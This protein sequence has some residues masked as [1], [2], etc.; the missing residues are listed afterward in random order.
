MLERR[1]TSNLRFSCVSSVALGPAGSVPCEADS[2]TGVSA[3]IVERFR[4]CHGW[5][6][7]G[8]IVLFSMVHACGDCRQVLSLSFCLFLANGPISSI[9]FII[10]DGTTHGGQKKKCHP[11][12]QVQPLGHA[13]LNNTRRFWNASSAQLRYLD[14]KASKTRINLRL[15]RCSSLSDPALDR[16]LR[17]SRIFRH[18]FNSS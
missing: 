6:L 16:S 11:R 8:S 18:N 14:K 12:R 1:S 17:W 15:G 7:L 10:D 3:A 9:V 2:E 5:R 4:M 13:S